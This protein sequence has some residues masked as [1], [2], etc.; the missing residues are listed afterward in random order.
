MKTNLALLMAVLLA[1]SLPAA[2]NLSGWGTNLVMAQRLARVADKPV[3]LYY[4]ATWC[5]PCKLMAKTTLNEPAVVA[6]LDQLS[7]VLLDI[8]AQPALAAAQNVSSVPT[9]LL[10]D[11][12][13]DELQR[14][15]GYQDTNRFRAWLAAGRRAFA[16]ASERRRQLNEEKQ[17]ILAA[18]RR[19]QGPP[20]ESMRRLFDVAARRENA[21]QEFAVGQLKQVAGRAPALLLPGLSHP[22]LAARIRTANALREVLGEQFEFDPWESAEVR[23]RQIADV[24]IQPGSPKLEDGGETR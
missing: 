13:G 2:E 4:T 18:M 1:C 3:L 23:A 21:A 7:R 19:P 9:F 15:I 5:G 20:P 14:T 17:S 6:D 10:L 11:A 24:R 16:G 8:D 22:N 12:D